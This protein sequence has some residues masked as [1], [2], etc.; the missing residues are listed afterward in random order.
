MSYLAVRCLRQVTIEGVKRCP[1]A[2]RALLSDTYVDDIITGANTT[3][4]ARLLQS[5]LRDLLREGGFE[6]RKWCSNSEEAVAS[7]PAHLRESD[8]N[9]SIDANG[10]VNTLTWDLNGTL[11][12]TN[13]N[14]GHRWLSAC[15]LNEECCPR[16]VS[17]STR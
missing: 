17:C 2:V 5:Q 1:T 10:V 16:S 12:P 3:E 7:V 8:T 9:L 6:A 13:F 11:A 4:K 15:L 14:S